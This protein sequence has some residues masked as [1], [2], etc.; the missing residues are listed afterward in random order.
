MWN[1]WVK[2]VEYEKANYLLLHAR[3]IVNDIEI[4][5]AKC[6]VEWCEPNS[7]IINHMIYAENAIAKAINGMKDQIQDKEG[8]K[9]WLE[10]FGKDLERAKKEC[11]AH[12]TK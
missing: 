10:N 8:F 2:R 9:K 5:Y 12:E 1:R 7:V 6:G 3:K 4:E 11:E